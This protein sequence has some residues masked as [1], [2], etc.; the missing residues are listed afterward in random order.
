MCSTRLVELKEEVL[1]RTSITV[2]PSPPKVMCRAA[3]LDPAVGHSLRS[4]HMSY[5]RFHFIISNTE[6]YAAQAVS[7][8]VARV[9]C[10]CEYSARLYCC[11]C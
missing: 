2:T 9:C 1:R 10:E 3:N 6:M 11:S 7:E 8:D 5:E 4:H